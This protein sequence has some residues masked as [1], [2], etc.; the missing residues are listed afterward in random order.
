MGSKKE[1][2]E[3]RYLRMHTFMKEVKELY[4]EIAKL[5]SHSKFPAID[6]MDNHYR[7]WTQKRKK[8][9][10]IKK[11]FLCKVDSP[12]LNHLH[13]AICGTFP[14]EPYK[15]VFSY[16][17]GAKCSDC[18][19]PH[20]G[21]FALYKLDISDFFYS[22]TRDAIQSIYYDFLED[23]SET[24]TSRMWNK[25]KGP[26]QAEYLKLAETVSYTIAIL[27][28]RSDPRKKNKEDAVL[29][30]GTSPASIISNRI[31]LPV[32]KK[33][34]ERSKKESA[35]YTRYSDNMFFSA[36]QHM[37]REFQEEVKKIVEDFEISGKKL[38][39]INNDKTSYLARWRQQRILGIVVNT[40]MN[41]PK[42]KEK[43]L[44][45]ALNHLYYD[46]LQLYDTVEKG[47]TELKTLQKSYAAFYRRADRIFGQLAYVYQIAP[48][49]YLK[50]STW[51]HATKLLR[52]EIGLMIDT[53][54]EEQ[55]RKARSAV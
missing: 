19:E 22:I 39:K 47:D 55:K 49:K 20:V 44:R 28:T 9:G 15:N 43:Y 52:D 2:V 30:I 46:L 34:T 13:S 14:M 3:E 26:T 4:P 35:V 25:S 51:H 36:G 11:R 17:K 12:E 10:K 33:L 42:G 18:A 16:R 31:L 29:P 45:S 40:K 38:F 21:A 50:Y 48:P 27:T 32:D 7:S 1:S 24:L 5:A 6:F 8:A 37:S 53:R 23:G 41:I 54:V